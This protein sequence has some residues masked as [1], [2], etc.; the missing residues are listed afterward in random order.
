MKKK[1]L[2][3]L[4]MITAF[5]E[6]IILD[7]CQKKDSCDNCPG[8]NKPPVA[9][10]GPDLALYLADSSITLDGDSSFDPDGSVAIYSWKQ[11]A[12]PNQSDISNS[13]KPSSTV[14]HLSPGNYQ[15]EL[16]VT[17]NGGLSAKDTVLIIAMATDSSCTPKRS[18]VNARLVPIGTLSQARI[19]MATASAST[20]ILFAGGLFNGF[21]ISTRVDIYDFVSNTWSMAELSKGR[22]NLS[23]AEAGTRIFFAG[24]YADIFTD[25]LYFTR[26]DMYDAL[27][28]T[29]STA[30]LS[31][32]RTDIAAA[33]LGDQVF[34]AGGY[35]YYN[36]V[37][38]YSNRIDIYNMTTQTWSTDSLS[39]GRA[40]L[41]AIQ[42]GNKIYF[43]GGYTGSNVSDKIDIYDGDTH[44]WSTSNLKEGRAFQGGIAVANKI[45]WAGGYTSPST[46]VT[47]SQVEILD[48]PTQTSTVTCLS[49][50][51]GSFGAVP[52]TDNIV[53]FIGDPSVSP[54]NFDIYNTVTQSWS[55]GVL[56][57]GLA[58]P[59]IISA[60]N[61]LFVA[62][63]ETY[64]GKIESN[65]VSILEW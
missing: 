48:I 2:L 34:F 13:S 46:G 63:G 45:Y 10:A 5:T 17:D 57:N 32:G 16:E 12:G 18:V 38:Y 62:G 22:D 41:S 21:N 61:K 28:N 23:V 40:G 25:I 1:S 31:Q 29:W 11:I 49:Q 27:T 4:M 55:I 58:Y 15:F 8:S 47:T 9:K 42:V 39:E 44:S 54:M 35:Y 36:N 19:A 43:A 52:G 26:I 3:F 7:S 53:F 37:S 24:G 59:G 14:N 65:Q 6:L 51:K 50:S 33:T 64:P 20:K 60:D 30:E 56:N